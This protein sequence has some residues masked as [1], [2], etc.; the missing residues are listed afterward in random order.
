VV[1]ETQ[2]AATICQLAIEGMGIGLTNSLTYVSDRFEALGLRA[3][4]FEPAIAFRSLMILPPHRARSRLVDEL[5][6]LLER[7]RDDLARACERRF[8][9]FPA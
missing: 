2:F 3:M 5:V 1:V 7:E 8:G 4:P 6:G 9:R